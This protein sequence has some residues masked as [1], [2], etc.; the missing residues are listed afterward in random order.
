[1]NAP[2]FGSVRVALVAVWRTRR[3]FA[4]HVVANLILFGLVWLWLSIPESRAWHL[5]LSALLAAAIALGALWLHGATLHL[6][7]RA[8]RDEWSGVTDSF[9]A[10]LR[11]LP[12]LL[13]WGAVGGMAFALIGRIEDLV[14]IL[15][16]WTSSALTFLLRRPVSPE[17]AEM[18][19]AIP[20][21]VLR[22]VAA[23][24][25]LLLLGSAVSE[26]GFGALRGRGLD[27]VIGRVGRIGLWW[28]CAILVSVG[29]GL[30]SV[31]VHWVP[32]FEGMRAQAAS[33]TVR[34]LAAYSL[35]IAA[36]LVLASIIGRAGRAAESPPVIAPSVR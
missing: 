30:P 16:E 3:I 21:V 12:A 24:L 18:V 33:M 2:R 25:G 7:R 23:P 11:V 22:W 34:L 1:M 13:V 35:A 4:L 29:L 17:R 32:E 36:W 28:R 15:S 31:L 20:V 5:L 19:L 26:E 27:R 8:H 6:F 14:P 9:R 10:T